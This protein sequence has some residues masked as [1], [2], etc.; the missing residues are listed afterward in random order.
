[1]ARAAKLLDKMRAN[2]RN[3][4]T[5]EQIGTVCSAYEDELKLLPPSGGSHY[6]LVYPDGALTIPAKRPIK[7]YYVK[8]V[9]DIIDDITV[10]KEH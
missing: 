8:Q 3:D 10:S 1:M 7:P 2:P 4:W 6:K 9:L 5:I